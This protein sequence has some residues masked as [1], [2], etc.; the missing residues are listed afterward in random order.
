MVADNLRHFDG[1]HDILGGFVVMPNDA[2]L[3][4]RISPDRTMLDQC[5]RWKHDQAV[6]VHSLLGRLGHLFQ[7]DSFDRLVR[8]E[9][10]FRK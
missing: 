2:H 8:D 6:Q 4:V 3:L 7:A 10:H 9:Q 1:D 5:C